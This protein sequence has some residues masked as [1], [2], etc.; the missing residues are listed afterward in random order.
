M[1][2]GLRQEATALSFDRRLTSRVTGQITA[3]SVLAGNLVYGTD[4]Y[5][6]IPGPLFALAGSIRLVDEATSTPFVLATLSVAQ[7]FA[8]TRN[9]AGDTFALSATDARI[10][11]LVG[12]TISQTVAPYVVARAFGGPVRWDRPEG[13]VTG[14][15][16]YHYQVGVGALVIAGAGI[17][18]TIEVAFVGERRATAGLGFAF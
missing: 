2:A 17:D 11:V 1:R 8:R 5:A 9:G 3:G 6:V 10:G 14:S 7:S 18:G 12:K 13:I 15:D 4:V 16:R